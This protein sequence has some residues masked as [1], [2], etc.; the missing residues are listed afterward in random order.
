MTDALTPSTEEFGALVEASRERI[1]RFLALTGTADPDD[2]VQR[3]VETA[4][5]ERAR[6]D[7]SSKFSTWLF[8][9]AHNHA[10]NERRKR[11]PV[12]GN[13]A[14]LDEAKASRGVFTSVL[15][16]ELAERLEL[17]LGR[18][19]AA[20]SE[21]F[22]LHHVEGMS[23]QDIGSIAGVTEVT[24]RVRAHRARH[25]LRGELGEFDDGAI[26]LPE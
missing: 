11:R 19:P 16:R 21:A 5:R 7:G 4:W 10:R 23:F 22:V 6:F 17:A 3:A 15:R 8:G 9:I 14:P 18:L 26:R 12:V 25:L 2:L 13:S 20:F 24:A 1:H